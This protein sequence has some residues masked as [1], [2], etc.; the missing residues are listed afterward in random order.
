MELNPGV[1]VDANDPECLGRI[2]CAVPG[3]FDT[4]NMA[5][6]ELP[7]V[8]PFSMGGYQRFS[9]MAKGAKI[10]LLHDTK[11][12]EAFWYLPGFEK[13]D[14]AN[15]IINRNEN[16][17]IL[18]SRMDGSSPSAIYYD[19]VDGINQKI[20]ENKINLK[21]NGDIDMQSNGSEITAN[22]GIVNI[23]KNGEAYEPAAMGNAVFNAL[24]KI[25]NAF[26]DIMMATGS[27]NSKICT[28]AQSAYQELAKLVTPNKIQSKAIKIN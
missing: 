20:G 17:E 3:I 16:T 23:G 13:N 14:D 28:A 1:V 10:W 18:F 5:I 12:H 2:R 21:A 6:E 11:S 24:D 26:K 22:G 8:Y 15:P 27:D 7:W 19:D 4:R 9:K 25:K